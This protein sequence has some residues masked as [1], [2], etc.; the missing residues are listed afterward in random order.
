MSV[1][2]FPALLLAVLTPAALLAQQVPAPVF[3]YKDFAAESKIEQQFLA[4]PDAKLAGQH[5]KTLTAEPHL[6]S[7]PEDHKT[8]E[9][10]AAKFR[11][12]GLDTEIVPYRV[13]MNQPKVVRIEAFDTSGKLLISG[14]TREHVEGD[15]GQDD[16][17]VVM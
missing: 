8:A 6:A 5:L 11:A 12:A 13:L 14:P 1:R 2:T 7:T 15:P 17:R 10:V 16:P 3:G 9:Y 4:V